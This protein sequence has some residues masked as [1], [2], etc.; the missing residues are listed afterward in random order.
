MLSKKSLWNFLIGAALILLIVISGYGETVLAEGRYAEDHVSDPLREA[1]DL[2]IT[3]RR[4]VG[5]DADGA[6]AKYNVAITKMKGSEYTGW[7]YFLIGELQNP[8]IAIDSYKKAI[9]SITSANI[10]DPQALNIIKERLTCL[11]LNILKKALAKY[12]LDKIEYPE[13][14]A[15]LS[16]RGL[17]KG[18]TIKDGWERP[19]SYTPLNMETVPQ[20]K[21][22]RYVLASRGADSKP[23]SMDDLLPNSQGKCPWQNR[24]SMKG[25]S[26]IGDKVSIFIK[27]KNWE[28]S[29]LI[30]SGSVVDGARVILA[31][32][33]GVIIAYG[34]ILELLIAE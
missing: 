12:Y 7:V 4:L 31:D 14:L 18:E 13:K 16:G 25:S 23:G 22:Q 32:A 30:Q 26:Q 9:A 21:R 3:G 1:L 20:F 29:K 8:A 19:F 6:I 24:F 27:E 11:R 2:L 34:A 28:K 10:N 15:E 5:K 17:V 33:G